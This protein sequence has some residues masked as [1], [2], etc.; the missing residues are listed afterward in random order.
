[1]LFL[2][3]KLFFFISDLVGSM[4]Y[5]LS[6]RPCDM[7]QLA[8]REMSNLLPEILEKIALFLPLPHICKCMQVC[9]LWKVKVVMQIIIAVQN[10]FKVLCVLKIAPNILLFVHRLEIEISSGIRISKSCQKLYINFE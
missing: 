9:K 10:V 2:N 4:L 1:M 6:K 7:D 3:S 5:I 8:N